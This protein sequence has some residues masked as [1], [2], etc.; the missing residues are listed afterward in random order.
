MMV[1]IRSGSVRI[2][3]YVNAV[4]RLSRTLVDDDG[5]TYR[6]MIEPGAFGKALQN[7]GGGLPALLNHQAERVLA[8]IGGADGGRLKL[9]EDTIGLHADMTSRDPELMQLAK[10][11]KLR[12][13][14][15][16][17]VPLDFKEEYTSGGE[18]H[19]IITDMELREVS[20]IDDRMVP[21]YAGTSIKARAEKKEVLTRAMDDVLVTRIDEIPDYSKYDEILNRLR[22]RST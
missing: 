13:W 22:K 4:G 15:F 16:G 2:E 21:A 20:V 3:G 9:E 17:F 10:D 6:E 7:A 1:E 11:G 8:S 12:G 19:V 5:L 18:R 14:S